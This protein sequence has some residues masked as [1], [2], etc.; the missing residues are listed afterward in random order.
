[1]RRLKVWAT[2][3]MGLNSRSEDYH[4]SLSDLSEDTYRISAKATNSANVC[5]ELTLN[6]VGRQSAMDVK[7]LSMMAQCW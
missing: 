4:F 3:E 7:G 5:Y 6:E 1:M 2:Q